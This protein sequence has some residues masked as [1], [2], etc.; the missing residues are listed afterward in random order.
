VADAFGEF[1]ARLRARLGNEAAVSV[2][3]EVE[4]EVRGR[5]GGQWIYVSESGDVRARNSLIVE[6]RLKG[7]S[8]EKIA[9]EF[10]LKPRQVYNILR[11]VP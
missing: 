3:G 4:R 5:W 9:R 1:V 2:I 8:V 7:Q 11:K 6:A 10:G